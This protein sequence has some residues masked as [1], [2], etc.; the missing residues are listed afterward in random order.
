MAK[1]ILLNSESG[2][3]GFGT[4]AA[5]TYGNVTDRSSSNENASPKKWE[6]IVLA[7]ACKTN[8]KNE[9]G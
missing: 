2:Y 9:S 3:A 6:R 8:K 1:Q 4:G 7:E 5:S